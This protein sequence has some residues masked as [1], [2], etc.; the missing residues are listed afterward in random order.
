MEGPAFSTKAE[1]KMYRQLEMD[2]IG[3]TNFLE[4]KLAREAEICY[5]TIAMVTDYDCWHP[6]H[7][8]VTVDQVIGNLMEN[9]KQ[10]KALLKHVLPSLNYACTTSCREAL[11]QGLMTPIEA[12]PKDTAKKLQPILKKYLTQAKK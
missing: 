10:A 3:M 8:D 11:K 6:K 4:A 5:L 12:I 1:S 9:S 7:A 2:I